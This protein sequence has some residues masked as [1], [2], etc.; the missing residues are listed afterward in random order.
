MQGLF[1]SHRSWPCRL[2]GLVGLASSVAALLSVLVSFL[3]IQTVTLI[4]AAIALLL[5]PLCLIWTGRVL[6]HHRP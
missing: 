1:L 3:G 2:G 4:T 6:G 5:H